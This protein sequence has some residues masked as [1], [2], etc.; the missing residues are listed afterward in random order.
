MEKG[1][2]GG[3]IAI[4]WRAMHEARNVKKQLKERKKKERKKKKKI[5]YLEGL[6]NCYYRTPKQLTR[7]SLK[8]FQNQTLANNSTLLHCSKIIHI[9]ALFGFNID[10]K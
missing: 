10:L 9:F 7:V 5:L 2:W 1:E 3:S 6:K 8:R 4:L